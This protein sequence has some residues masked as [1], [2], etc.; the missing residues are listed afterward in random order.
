[1]REG[2]P[3][4]V[5]DRSLLFEAA[6]TVEG[7]RNDAYGHPADDFD[8]AASI[9]SGILGVEVTARQVA[10][11]MVGVKLARQV[12]APKRDNVVDAIGY[13]L[14]LDACERRP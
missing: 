11:C 5:I 10:M 14:C 2:E 9:W 12:H 6:D 13:L 1:M 3:V 7:P 4:G 8:R